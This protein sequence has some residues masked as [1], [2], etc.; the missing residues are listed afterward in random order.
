MNSLVDPIALARNRARATD[1]FLQ[2]LAADELQDRLGMVNKEFS[3]PA[4]VT[5]F[6]DVWSDCIPNATVVPAQDVLTLEH[7]AHDLVIHSLDLHWANDPVGQLIQCK[8][9]LQPDGLLLVAALGGRTLSELRTSL[10]EAEARISSGLSARVAP[11]AEIRDF[12]ALLQRA[13]LALPVAD[14]VVQNVEYADLGG[15]MRDLRCMGETNALSAR[16]RIP[17]KRAVFDA[18]AETYAQH[19][20][21]QSGKVKATY[22]FVILTGWAPDDSQPQPLRPGSATQRLADALGAKEKNLPD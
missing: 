16:L 17:T 13:G 19:F 9:A 15:V 14:S 3:A 22:E 11:M 20:S 7:A 10:A 18:A 2:S 21:T 1:M 4:I 5:P 12:G 6:P 8:R